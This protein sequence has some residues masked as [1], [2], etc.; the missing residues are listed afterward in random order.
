MGLQNRPALV[1]AILVKNG[2]KKL[3]AKNG[4]KHLSNSVCL[5]CLWV[6]MYVNASWRS[7]VNMEYRCN[8]LIPNLGYEPGHWGVR[9]KKN[10]I[11]AEN[12]H[13]IGLFFF[14][15]TTN[16]FEI[17]KVV[18]ITKILLIWRVK[19]MEIRCQGVR[20]WK[21]VGNRSSEVWIP[22]KPPKSKRIQKRGL[23][24][25]GLLRSE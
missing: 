5:L 17:T 23:R 3:C 12:R 10:W 7:A 11:T 15:V 1:L 25:S 22:Y 6:K 18:L 14:T 2:K 20:K 16:K 4:H 24:C 21:K 8:A 19:F 13:V 9:P